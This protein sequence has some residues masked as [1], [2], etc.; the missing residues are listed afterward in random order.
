V[1][2]TYVSYTR[3][4]CGGLSGG[5]NYPGRSRGKSKAELGFGS[6]QNIRESFPS[7]RSR[8][9]LSIKMHSKSGAPLLLLLLMPP[10]P[11]PNRDKALPPPTGGAIGEEGFGI[12]FAGL[13]A[14]LVGE[15]EGSLRK[16]PTTFA[17]LLAVFWSVFTAVVAAACK[18]PCR[19]RGT[20]RTVCVIVRPTT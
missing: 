6:S 4:R 19:A 14:P 20:S 2:E 10:C 1:G 11:P 13:S 5:E 12:P 8:I 17:T 18:L 16:L 3:R 7:G 9:K 15:S